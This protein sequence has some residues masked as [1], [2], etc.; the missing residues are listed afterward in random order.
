MNQKAT[1]ANRGNKKYRVR[2]IMPHFTKLC[3]TIS[4][5]VNQIT[6]TNP[7]SF[8]HP[9]KCVKANPLL[10][11][12]DFANVNR[13]QAGLLCQLFLTHAGLVAMFPNGISQYFKLTRARHNHLAK[14]DG[15]KLETPN[16][17]LFLSCKFFGGRVKTC[18]N[19]ERPGW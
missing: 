19:S 9:Q 4:K 16:M 13:M 2:K 8:G 1:V 5:L 11:P 10:A 6:N 17:G 12:F 14:Q 7:K 18:S 3:P 15:P